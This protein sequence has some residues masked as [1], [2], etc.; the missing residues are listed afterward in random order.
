VIILLEG[1]AVLCTS[2]SF[3][4]VCF[5]NKYS[6]NFWPNSADGS[7]IGGSSNACG[8]SS[9]ARCVDFWRNILLYMQVSANDRLTLVLDVE[10]SKKEPT[11][12]T[13]YDDTETVSYFTDR[14]IGTGSFGIVYQARVMDTNEVVAIKKVLQDK[15]FKNREL[16]IM[17]QLSHPNIIRLNHC[18]Y[19]H[20][21]KSDEVYLNLVQEYVP[22]TLY[23]IIRSYAKMRQV[24]P[25]IYVKCFAYQLMRA[26]GYLHACGFCHRDIKPQNLLVD[27]QNAVLKICDFGSAK[28]LVRGEPNVSY[29]SSRYYRA[30]ELIFG[31][32]HYSVAIDLWSAGCV[33]AEMLLGQPLFPGGTGV[34]QVVE[35]IKVLGTPTRDEMYAMN[36]SYKEFKF[37]AVERTPW[38]RVRRASLC[39]PCA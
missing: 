39:R 36:E 4:V 18:F 5:K 19:S 6:Q 12:L 30:P 23:R 38:G 32:T 20:G 25:L 22:D 28:Q 27:R 16:Q 1:L 7:R 21:D 9:F 31:A 3:F 35:I 10:E 13:G 37:P 34:D 11:I 29:I 15:R 14:V 8:H 26:L 17:R 33:V 2:G 24:L